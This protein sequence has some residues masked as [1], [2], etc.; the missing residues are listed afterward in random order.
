[1]I[2]ST[3]IIAAT[4]VAMTAAVFYFAGL[5]DSVTITR[6]TKGPYHIVYREYRGLYRGVPFVVNDVF[7]YVRDTL[8]IKSSTPF[9]VFH[10]RPGIPDRD[11]LRSIGGAMVDT[12]PAVKPELKTGTIGTTD[13]VVGSYRLRGFF[14]LAAGSYKFYSAL[15]RYLESHKLQQ[16]GSAMEIYDA[17]HRSMYFIVPI[18][19]PAVPWSAIPGKN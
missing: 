4:V 16:R 17:R 10:D 6:E 7:R 19:S 11:S 3:V 15:P 18:D 13:A 14:S 9:A 8:H 2:R 12:I 1:M 5:F